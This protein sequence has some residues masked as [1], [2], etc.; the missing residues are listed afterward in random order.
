MIKD[1]K[2]FLES[3]IE[4]QGSCRHAEC[5][6]NCPI[7]KVF[8]ERNISGCP[9]TKAEEIAIELYAKGNQDEDN[10]I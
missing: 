8:K 2:V 1:I 4:N 3:I 5:A 10:Q 6:T 9:I 7:N